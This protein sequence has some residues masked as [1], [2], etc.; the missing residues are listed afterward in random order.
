MCNLEDYKNIWVFVETEC[1]KA[2]SVGYELINVARPLAD[3][4]ACQLVAVVIGKNIEPVAVDAIRYGADSAIV[5]DGDE[6]EYYTTDAFAKVVVAL[7]EKYKPETLMIG[8][9]NNGRDLGPRV[10]CRLRT[11]LTADCTKIGIDEDTGNVAW[12]RP[13]FGGNLMA[14]IMCPENRPQM[15]TVRPGVFKKGAYDESRTG[16]IVKEEIHVAPEEIRT[17]LIERVNEVAEAVNLEEAEII[18]AGGRGIGS[19]DNFKMLEELAEVLGGKVGCSRPV[20]EAGWMPQVRQV[21]QS[22]K[23]VSPKLYFAIG[24]SGAIQHLTGIAG[25]DTVVAIN[26]DPDA[27]IFDVADYGIVGN[28]SEVV[29]AMIEAF[30]AK[31]KLA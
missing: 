23:T 10:S 16:E 6:Y 18:V 12:T 17:K 20:V 7:V 29:P 22:G 24:I 5:V 8:A 31:N 19:A 27:P 11:G 30:K 13:T 26:K 25:A 9:T 28:F 4:K 14:T 21:G 15:G 1:G 2:K 3:E